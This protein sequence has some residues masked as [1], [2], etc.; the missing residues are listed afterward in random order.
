MKLTTI[1]IIIRIILYKL[2]IIKPTF[3]QLIITKKCNLNCRFCF[4]P[5]EERLKCEEVDTKEVFQIIDYLHSIG[6]IDLTITGGEPLLRSDLIE[7]AKYAKKRGFILNLISNGT[8]INR[9][10]AKEICKYFDTVSISLD[11]FKDTHNS[12]RRNNNAFQLAIRAIRNLSKNR[13]K[14]SVGIATT[15]MRENVSEIIP[16]FKK[17]RKFVNFVGIQPVHFDKNRIPQPSKVQHLIDELILMKKENPNYI[18]NTLKFIELIPAFLSGKKIKICDAGKLY[19]F[20]STDGSISPCLVYTPINKTSITK[21]NHIYKNFNSND[22]NCNGCLI[23]CT[24][25]ISLLFRD[26]LREFLLYLQNIP[27][28]KRIKHAIRHFS[29]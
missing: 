14:C 26:P 27:F 15:L 13:G 9:E 22:I 17:L 6:I 8:L 1:R 21:K 4:I 23:R 10:A 3:A 25:D 18:K 16:L 7:I 19:L 20:A 24:T 29:K 28:A 2:G 5:K 12:L 11:G